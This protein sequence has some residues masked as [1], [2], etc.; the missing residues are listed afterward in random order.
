MLTSTRLNLKHLMGETIL[1]L[2]ENSLGAAASSAT[3]PTDHATQ[4]ID[5]ADIPQP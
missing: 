5:P 1:A 3:D 2:S 4:S